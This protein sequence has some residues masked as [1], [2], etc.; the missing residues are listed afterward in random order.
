MSTEAAEASERPLRIALVAG[1][2]SGDQLGAGLIAE[3][4]QRYPD[5]EF[6]GVGGQLMHQAGQTLWHD[7]HA[8]A[9]M[10]LVEVLKHLPRLLALRKSLLNRIIAWKPDVFIGIDAPDFNLGLEK[11]L[12]KRG[13]KTVHYVS[14]SVW[15]WRASRAKK[16][17]QSADLVLCLFPMEPPIYAQYGANAYFV[18]HPIAER[19][20]LQPNQL[21]AKTALQLQP[22]MP[23]LAL[24]PG[25]RLSEIEKL[26]PVFL[27]AAQLIQHAAPKLQIAIPAA[28]AKCAQAIK[29]ITAQSKLQHLY[30]YDGHSHEAMIAADVILLASGTAALE[31]ML[32][33]RPMVVAYKIS[34][35]TYFIVKTFGLLKVEHVSLPNVLANQR[36]VPELMQDDC[37]A[38]KIA[39]EILKLLGSDEHQALIHTFTD[40]HLQLKQDAN[41]LAADGVLRLLTR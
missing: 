18:G 20:D 33:K 22:D 15:A 12:K 41:R 27:N 35:I 34:P 17:G 29:D 5:A 25:S 10:G 39:A 36:I 4:K 26:L 6:A 7:Y 23:T 19:F 1:E 37:T 2:A 40:I 13:I 16:I 32:A 28:N 14:P 31:A 9:V 3:I 24:L 30:F 38:E 8:L 21:D 11:K